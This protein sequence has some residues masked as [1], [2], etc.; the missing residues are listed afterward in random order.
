MAESIRP[1]SKEK[2]NEKSGLES[3]QNDKEFRTLCTFLQLYTVEHPPHYFKV[4][5]KIISPC[6]TKSN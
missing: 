5:P 3:L 6:T 2:L 4:S 1:T